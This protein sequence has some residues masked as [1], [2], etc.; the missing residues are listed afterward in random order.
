MPQHEWAKRIR[1]WRFGDQNSIASVH[2][3]LSFNPSDS[4][5][6]YLHKSITSMKFQEEMHFFHHEKYFYISACIELAIMQWIITDIFLNPQITTED[7]S[8]CPLLS[9]F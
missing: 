6:E 5:T 9:S 1:L 3:C 4:G 7:V 8:L 2:C